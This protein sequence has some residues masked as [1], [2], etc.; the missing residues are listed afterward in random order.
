MKKSEDRWVYFV[1]AGPGALRYLTLEG[2]AA[3][4]ESA[5]IYAFDPYPETFASLIGDRTVRDPFAYG[6]K[7]ITAQVEKAMEEGSV[8]FLVPGDMTVFSPFLPLVQHF[9][10]RSRVIAGV[11]IVNAASALLKRT[12]E[13]PSVSSKVLLTSPKHMD[14]QEEAGSLGRL[15]SLGGTMVLY[16]NNRPMAR[17]AAELAEGY[18][19]DTPVAVAYRI[20]LPEERIYH[21]TLATISDAV[22]KD[23][24]FGL[25]SGD[26]SMGIVIVGAVLTAPVDPSFWDSR[27]EKFWDRKKRKGQGRD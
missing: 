26:P 18:P 20:G 4:E 11:G 8:A 12:L 23:D 2:K 24:L 17:L 14:R 25:E 1:G 6:F 5:L 10:E 21:G 3:L 19:P 9:G 15:A 22:G 27:K 16:M 13:M 7:E